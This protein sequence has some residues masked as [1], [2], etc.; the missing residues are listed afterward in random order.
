LLRPRLTTGHPFLRTYGANL[1]NSSKNVF[2]RALGYSPSSPVSVCGTDPTRHNLEVFLGSPASRVVPYGTPRHT[3]A[4]ALRICQQSTLVR[5]TPN[6][7]DAR[8]FGKR[9]PIEPCG[10]GRILTPCPLPTSFDLGLGPTNPPMTTRAEETL[11][12]RRGGFS[13]PNVTHPEILTR[14]RSTG[15]YDPASQL[16]RRSPTT[17]CGVHGFGVDFEPRYIFGAEF[18]NQ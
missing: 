10:S 2:P 9:Y 18:L 3:L 11:N 8:N 1:P 16:W 12:F 5:R 13:P 14:H 17:P 4:Y 6:H 15:P 7:A